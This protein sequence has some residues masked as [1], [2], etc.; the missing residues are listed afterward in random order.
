MTSNPSEI[1]AQIERTRSSLS[2]NVDALADQANPAHIAQRQV[3]KAK[4]AGGRL[5]DRVLG[6]AEDVRDAAVEG[7]HHAVEGVRDAAGGLGD[8][9]AGAPRAVRHQAQGN[10][11]AAGMVAFGVGLLVAAAFPPSRKERE[12]A[13]AVKEQAQPLTDS[14]AAAGREVAEQLAEPAKQVVDS[15]RG[16][17]TDA[18]QTVQEEGSSALADV[19]ESA[20]QTASE[21]ADTARDSARQVQDDAGSAID[22]ARS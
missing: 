11:L 13:Q 7:V 2:D 15:L 17:A 9:V 22:D 10:P 20:Q 12:L 1:R 4:A 6:S 5:L 16:S 19:Q 18:V 21:V 8:S 3:S 14:L